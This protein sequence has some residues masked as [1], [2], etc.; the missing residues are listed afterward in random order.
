MKPIA[1]ILAFS[2]A[3]CLGGDIGISKAQGRAEVWA[4]VADYVEK[5]VESLPDFAATSEP[6]KE[7]IVNLKDVAT[8]NAGVEKREAFLGV[9]GQAANALAAIPHPYAKAAG[10][11][12]KL[13]IALIGLLASKRR[14]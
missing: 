6:V 11:G 14:L 13:L 3:G 5:E 9:A 1:A 10:N 7:R 4:D 8:T 2:L 12:L